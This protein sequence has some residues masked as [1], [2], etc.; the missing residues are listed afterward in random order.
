MT[1][2]YLDLVG[3]LSGD[4]CVAALLDLGAPLDLLQQRIAEAGLNEVELEIRREHRH[5]IAGARFLVTHRSGALPDQASPSRVLPLPGKLREQAGHRMWKDI[6]AQLAG[7]RLPGTCAGTARRIFRVLAEAEGAVHGIAPE[8]VGFHEVGTWDS[9]A[10]IV[11]VA[12]AIEHLGVTEVYCSPVPLGGGQVRTAHGILPIPA[13]ATLHLLSGFS[14][15]QGGP[16]YERVTP[17]GAAILA[18]LARPVPDPFGYVPERV[19]IGLGTADRPEVANLVRAVLGRAV[20]DS[21][22]RN[23]GAIQEQVEL[24]AANLDDSN[25]EWIG[26]AMER[27]FAEG[28]LDVALVPIHMKKHRPGT[29]V[30]VLYRPDLRER[31][32]AVLFGEVTTLGV[33]FQTWERVALARQAAT[34]QTPWG[35]V[36]GKL[37]NFAGRQRFAPEYE[38]CR[39]IAESQ[40]IPLPEVYRAAEY[41]FAEQGV[42]AQ[43][44]TPVGA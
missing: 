30:Q 26:H 40:G 24:A 36:A 5:Q 15:V 10:D 35:P 22:N 31:M 11:C 12:A 25:P 18:A 33:R 1:L 23:D 28:A 37:S 42:K 27:L 44:G 8:E 21:A 19:G 6:D 4:M 13:P 39:A 9:I 17:T 38:D 32:L 43:Q 14:V 16:A 3:G 7:S 20:R 41:A 29:Q 2:L 34:V